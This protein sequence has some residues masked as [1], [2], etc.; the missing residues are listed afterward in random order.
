[1]VKICNYVPK[2]KSFGM[3]ERPSWQLCF[4]RVSR[5]PHLQLRRTK[6]PF[7]WR[8]M[9]QV[10][11]WHCLSDKSLGIW[12]FKGWVSLNGWLVSTYILPQKTNN[13]TWC[14]PF[15]SVV[16]VSFD[17]HT[18]ELISLYFTVF[19]VRIE[20]QHQLFISWTARIHVS[21]GSTLLQSHNA[22]KCFE[23]RRSE[24]TAKSKIVRKT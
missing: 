8:L 1:M 23:G 4:R 19:L 21:S 10:I 6:N 17:G 12:V 18:I 16:T 13:Y 20:N 3:L 14:F 24:T 7:G 11:S 2:K 5:G 9:F 22:L 15:F